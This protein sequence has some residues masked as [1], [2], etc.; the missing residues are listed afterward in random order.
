MDISNVN[1]EVSVDKKNIFNIIQQVCKN[2]DFFKNK[3]VINDDLDK[4]IEN[5]NIL[6]NKLKN[7]NS[8]I[9]SNYNIIDLKIKNFN[10]ELDSL[11][12]NIFNKLEVIE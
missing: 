1:R 9:T 12:N 8:K 4:K 5:E 11:Q 2:N 7:L 3:S 6:K 10:D